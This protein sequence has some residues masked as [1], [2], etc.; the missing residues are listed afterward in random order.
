MNKKMFQK[1]NKNNILVI[2]IILIA[3]VIR[4]IN[5]PNGIKGINCD[6]AM[7][8]I[9]ARSI[10]KTGCDIYGTRFPIYFEAWQIAGQSA[11]PTYLVALSIRLLGDSLLAIRLPILLISLISIWIIYLLTKK[12]F[13]EKVA[14]IV[15]FLTAINPW[16]I[17][18][19]QWNLD[20]NLF[21]HI[22]LIAI[23]L[24]YKGVEE[25][26]RKFIYSSMIFFGLSMYCYGIAIY[27]VPLFLLIIGIYLLKNKYVT[28][29]EFIF[30]VVL[31]LIISI[32]IL[33]MYL[34][35]FLKLDTIN[36][37]GISIQRFGYD[38]RK[39]DMIIFS[40]HPLKQL[41]INISYI[42]NLMLFQN[43]A[44]VW[45]AIST[46]GTLYM[47]ST[48]FVIAGI[49]FIIEDKKDKRKRVLLLW[50]V[51]SLMT[52]IFVNK[53]NINRM[54]MI[55]YS[56]IILTGY[57]IYEFSKLIKSKWGER[58]IVLLYIVS[59]LLFSFTYY[60]SYQD[61]ISNSYTFDKGLVKACEFVNDID[62][63]E[64]IISE[65][66]NTSS[67]WVYYRYAL[68]Y[69]HESAISREE[70]LSYYYGN[71]EQINWFNSDKKKYNTIDLKEDNELKENLYLI[72]ENEEN[73]IK[74]ISD[75]KV[76]TFGKYLVLQKIKGA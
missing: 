60:N 11:L 31:Y 36:F 55:W 44:L 59:F 20:C 14:I 58:I 62:E 69:N 74:N 33:S 46:F 24:L 45:N 30:C 13:N 23:Y 68:E 32:P 21:P 65:K 5:W 27:I 19:S 41:R 49:I 43:D 50:F 10:M 72:R 3:I 8:A 7:M 16:H 28:I 2:S 37:L 22:L 9:N 17:M 52:G 12:V 64:I 66:A 18:Q 61:R 35:N 56:M 75:Y 4:I 47:Q 73:N 71:N 57:G 39:N 1:I 40:N 63:K 34:I 25:K 29:K 70:L 42:L 67:E 51:I 48:I 38:S 53:T 6:E 15:L 76:N 26:K 54:N